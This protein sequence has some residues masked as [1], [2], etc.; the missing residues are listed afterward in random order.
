MSL[1]ERQLKAQAGRIAADGGRA[2]RERPE[3]NPAR[4]RAAGHHSCPRSFRPSDAKAA[5]AGRNPVREE[6]LHD[7]RVRMQ[8]EVINAFDTLLA[9]RDEHPKTKIE[10]IVDR[11]IRGHNFAVN[12]D[13]RTRL[14]QEMID[15]ITGFGPL[16]PLLNDPTITEVMVNGPEHIYIERAGKIRASIRSS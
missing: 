7:I 6:M 2:R 15:E 12:R 4:R 1:L 5:A 13:E 16:E 3:R 11:V 8:G 9:A 14:V 10:G